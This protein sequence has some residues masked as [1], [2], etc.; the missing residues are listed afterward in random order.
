M[1]ECGVHLCD[2]DALNASSGATN[3]KQALHQLR[4]RTSRV[5][6]HLDVD[7]FDPSEAPG[8]E[9][10]PPGGLALTKVA[11]MLRAIRELFEVSAVGIASYDPEQDPAGR[12]PGAVRRVL[13]GAL[14]QAAARLATR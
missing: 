3:L 11:E 5:Y 9:F 13:A 1:R 6:L 4:E 2:A 10:S 7:V 14:P 12:V 8:N